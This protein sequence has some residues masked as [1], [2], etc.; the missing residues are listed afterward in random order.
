MKNLFNKNT[1]LL[2]FGVIII[3]LSIGILILYKK[4][5]KCL[6]NRK[7]NFTV[8]RPSLK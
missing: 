5:N 4:Y 3:I 6:D 7:G 8:N 2:I 1:D